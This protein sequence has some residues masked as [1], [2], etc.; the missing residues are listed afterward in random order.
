MVELQEAKRALAKGALAELTEAELKGARLQDL[1]ASSLTGSRWSWRLSAVRPSS[2]SPI[3]GWLPPLAHE[4]PRRR[5]TTRP[6][7][8]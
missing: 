6:D 5:T 1:T 4:L 2:Y 3:D 8:R 7:A